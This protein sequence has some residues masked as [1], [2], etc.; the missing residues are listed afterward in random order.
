MFSKK[1][2]RD[3]VIGP[4]TGWVK[5]ATR[6]F[7]F[8]LY[9]FIHP[10]WFIVSL[11]I[12]AVL[13]I[14][15]PS[16]YGVEFETIPQWY[17]QQWNK[18]YNKTGLAVKDKVDPLKSIAEAEIKKMVGR[19][20]NVKAVEKKP[21]REELVVY[22][23]PK[24]L[25]RK[26]FEQAQEVPV[27]VKATITSDQKVVFK[28]YDNLGLVYL[29]IPQKIEGT[30]KIIN[31]NELKVKNERLFLYGIYVD[32]SSEQGIKTSKYL[33]DEFGDKEI[34]CWIGAYSNKGMPTAI[35][36]YQGININQRLVDLKYSTNVSLN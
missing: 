17:G 14:G 13:V 29:E 15:I 3:D 35:C 6:F 4:S 5:W 36:K 10:L 30:A 18:Y 1:R 19:G 2:K 23:A 32:P 27:D 20:I 9:P 11:V 16:Y 34:E 12:I 22:D 26:I 8:I 31:A 25:N 7:R 21:G 33:Q 28:R 24:V